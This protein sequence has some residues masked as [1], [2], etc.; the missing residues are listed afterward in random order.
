MTSEQHDL[1]LLGGDLAERIAAT[2]LARQG[3]RVLHLVP[4]PFEDTEPLPC[5]AALEKLLAVLDARHLVRQQSDSFQLVTGNVR[6][7][8]CGALPLAAELAREFPEHHA[9]ILALLSQ[10]DNWGRKLGLLLACKAPDSPWGPLRSLTLYRRLLRH[11]LPVRR[12]Q[13]P[14][15]RLLATLPDKGAQ[16]S[17]SQLL[18]GLCLAVPHR[19]SVAEAALR[20]H[21][22]TRP[23]QIDPQH[24][25]SLLA[26]RYA[27]AGGL[28]RPLTELKK[29]DF[30]AKRLQNITLLD[31]R[32][33]TARQ[34]ILAPLPAGVELP[35]AMAAAL[36]AAYCAPR[37]SISGPALQRP[38]LLARRVILGGEP[39]LRLTWHQEL[40]S[41][42]QAIIEQACAADTAL[43]AMKAAQRRLAALLPFSDFKLQE[44]GFPTTPGVLPN[45]LWPGGALPLP[46]GSNALYC[47]AFTRLPSAGKSAELMLGQ[48]AAGVLQQ[49]LG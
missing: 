28:S 6:L 46:V 47:H 38:P 36:P 1:I 7:E 19:L 2:L 10:L 31:G 39:P 4:D 20:W 15:S 26:E 27:A 43:P 49:R 24:L 40:L 35:S 8:I 34:F 17:L 22:A 41:P 12:L 48:A 33:L 13:Q 18:A 21:S 23:E 16:R 25:S 30:Q 42:N 3:Y 14:V 32:C 44:A 9:S 37:W 11:K 45:N 29:I 5:C